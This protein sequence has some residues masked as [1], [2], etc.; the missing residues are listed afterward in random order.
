MHAAFIPFKHIIYRC[1]ASSCIFQALR[2]WKNKLYFLV[3]H[4]LAKVVLSQEKKKLRVSRLK[5]CVFVIIK[6]VGI[7]LRLSL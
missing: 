3:M 1:V 4:L 5:V 7:K 6:R 2:P